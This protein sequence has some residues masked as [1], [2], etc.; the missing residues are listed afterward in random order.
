MIHLYSERHGLGH[1]KL[2]KHR[3]AFLPARGRMAALGCD[4]YQDRYVRE[5]GAEESGALSHSVFLMPCIQ[6]VYSERRLFWLN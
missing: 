6:K 3:Y 4:E 5:S 1:R 2:Q